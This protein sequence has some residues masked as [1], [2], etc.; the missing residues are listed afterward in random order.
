[1][2]LELRHLKVV[3]AIAETGSVTK[4]ASQLGLAQP[5]L[6]AQLQRIERTLGGPLFDRDRR[7][8]RPTALGELVLSRARVLL[9]AM[10]GLQ[11][12]AARLA[13][14]GTSRMS[15]YRIG[16]IGGP[17][18]AHLL[19]RLSAAQPE[20]AISTYASYSVDEL[21]T[22]ALNG[23]LDFVQVG[24]CGD[25]LPSAD[26]GLVWDTIAVDAVCVLMT[27]DHPQAKGTEVDLAELATEQWAAAPGDGCFET[28]FAASCA[29]AG[30]TPRRVLETDVRAC[31]DMVELGVAIGLCQPTF[32]PP[33]G[34]T[35]RPL[36]GAPLRW[37]LILGWHPESPAAR[38]APKVTELARD[39]YHDVIAR[40]EG[41]VTW[42]RDHPTLGGQ[43]LAAA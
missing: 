21:A 25:A 31:I 37:R 24:V 36:K 15:R 16:A 13:A 2:N 23:K 28:C 1:M 9:P 39:A 12:E 29:R 17:V 19:H 34:L 32:R 3:C 7:G 42:T 26:F 8:A 10:K 41:Y 43:H 38:Y 35:T 30:F 5:A 40:N 22:M 14:S 33:A 20:S 27:E 6:T 4:A 18:F 11:D